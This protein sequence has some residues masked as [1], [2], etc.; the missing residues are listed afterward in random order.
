M[1]VDSMQTACTPH[2]RGTKPLVLNGDYGVQ[3]VQ[4]TIQ[5]PMSQSLAITGTHQAKRRVGRRPRSNPRNITKHDGLLT[6]SPQ[7]TVH[8]WLCLHILGGKALT[9]YDFL[10]QQGHHPVFPTTDEAHIF[11]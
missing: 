11:S 5:Q 3:K 4:Y 9:Q 6:K 10:T 8:A 7:S 1:S 2:V